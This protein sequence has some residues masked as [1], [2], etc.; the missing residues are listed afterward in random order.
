M[1]TSY[2]TYENLLRAYQTCKKHKTNSQECMEFTCNLEKN[3]LAL[4]REL[5]SRQY[6]PG[7]AVAFV[8]TKPKLREVFAAQ[9]RDRVVHH[10]LYNYLA[11]VY[12]PR[13][14]YD[15]WACRVGKGTHGAMKRLQDFEWQA[16]EGGR[17]RESYY[18]QM[19]I[20]SFFTS[21]DKQCLYSILARNI[22]NPEILWLSKVI[23]FHDPARDIPPQLNSPPKLFR[24]L[25]R[26]K[27]LFTVKRGRGLPIGNLTSQFF[28]N[29]YLNELDCYIKHVLKVKRYVRYVDDWIII[30]TSILELRV[31]E[32]VIT[33]F[34]ESSLKLVIQTKKTVV[35]R[36]SDGIDFVGYI[37]RPHYILVRRRVVWQ[38]R[39][40]VESAMVFGAAEQK[41]VVV[42]YQGHMLKAQSYAL[43]R[44]MSSFFGKSMGE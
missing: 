35:G 41:R 21:I 23:I 15:S 12:E 42:S 39:R 26:D 18:L 43:R 20:K 37:V 30:G 27:S 19:D 25:P 33:E 5:R 9:F 38:C 10:L 40:A 13:F 7:R 29:M 2:F 31:Y 44:A 24:Q 32:R 34:V 4:E 28:A 11:P 8:V 22:K 16:S 6:R 14:I 1:R 36:V 3:L 17:N